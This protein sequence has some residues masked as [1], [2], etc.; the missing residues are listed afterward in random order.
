MK[1]SLVYDALIMAIGATLVGIG[2]FVAL[3]ASGLTD[4]DRA[5]SA[6]ATGTGLAWLAFVAGRGE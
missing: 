4:G 5:L 2:V 1:N 6:I 3:G